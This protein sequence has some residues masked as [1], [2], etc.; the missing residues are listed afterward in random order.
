MIE[1]EKTKKIKLLEELQKNARASFSELAEITGLT[2]QTVAKT[3]NE[4][5]KKGIIWGYTA[6]FNPKLIG[7]KPF[8]FLFKLDISFD[9]EDFFKKITDIKLI[10][11]HEEIY[12]V[13]T[14][15][16]LHGSKDILALIWTK[17]IIEAKKLMINY[18]KIF[19]NNIKDIELIEIITIFRDN[20]I[21]NPK[22]IEEWKNLL[23]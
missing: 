22:M 17:D 5:E 18:K 16:F 21:A 6:I 19:K 2:R 7:K 1:I 10:K 8:V 14:S 9:T 4:L 23:I 11:D 3:I 12:G 15:M 20:G 13:K